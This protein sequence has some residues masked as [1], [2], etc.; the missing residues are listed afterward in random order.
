MSSGKKCNLAL[1]YYLA[2]F[3]Y[4]AKID[5]IINVEVA[6]N[7]SEEVELHTIVDELP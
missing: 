7:K 4:M 2:G 3:F 6:C 5:M 1:V